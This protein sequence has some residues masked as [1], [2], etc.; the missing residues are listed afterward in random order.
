MFQDN[1]LAISMDECSQK[2]QSAHMCDET[3]SPLDMGIAQ[4][5]V[6]SADHDETDG[7]L[8][9]SLLASPKCN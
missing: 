5:P 2:P 3:Q 7:T 8:S 6:S 4:K 1:F 9:Q